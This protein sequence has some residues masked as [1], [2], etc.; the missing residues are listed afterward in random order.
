MALARILGTASAVNRRALGTGHR[1]AICE[2][3]GLDPDDPRQYS[4]EIP[5]EYLGEWDYYIHILCD[6]TPEREEKGQLM[7]EAI[8]GS[9]K[10]RGARFDRIG[11]W[12]DIGTKRFWAQ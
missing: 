7:A 10:E 6:P 3:I 9:I 5:P 4:I 2:F 11:V 1:Q 8:L 12:L